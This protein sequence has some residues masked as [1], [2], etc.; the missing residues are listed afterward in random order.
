MKRKFLPYLVF[1]LLSLAVGAISSL[2]VNSGMP[3]YQLA[4]KPPLT[5][6]AIV[7]PI[8]WTILYLLMGFSA[9]RIWNSGAETRQSALRIFILQ[10][11]LNALWSVWFFGY[12]A[13]LFAFFWLLLLIAAIVAML[14]AFYRIDPLAALLQLPYLLWCC[15]AACLNLGVWWLN[16]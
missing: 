11:L 14:R 12:Q 4:E 5:P 7:F 15:F 16:H 10:L 1:I 2:A 3:A 8:V 9:A 6:P 13:Y